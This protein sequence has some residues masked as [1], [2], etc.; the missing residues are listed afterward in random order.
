MAGQAAGEGDIKFAEVATVELD[1]TVHAFQL[2]AHSQPASN[3]RRASPLAAGSG[4]ARQP[5]VF[6]NPNRRWLCTPFMTRPK[7]LQIAGPGNRGGT[8]GC[9]VGNVAA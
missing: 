9:L 5:V 1:G 4:V 7:M 3:R 6:A 2:V 8:A